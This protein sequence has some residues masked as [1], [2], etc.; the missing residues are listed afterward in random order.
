ML[1]LGKTE[2]N[3]FSSKKAQDTILYIQT[4][5]LDEFAVVFLTGL[6][7]WQHF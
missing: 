5:T 3:V 7:N 2:F 1:N 4:I 6:F